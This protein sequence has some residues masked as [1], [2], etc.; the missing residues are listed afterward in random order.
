MSSFRWPS[1][2]AVALSCALTAGVVG[3][4]AMSP[5]VAQTVLS[6]VPADPA[7]LRL[8]ERVEQLEQQLRAKTG[9]L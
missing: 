5:A 1:A 2:A 3:P 6:P 4:A 8:Q 7:T 9:E